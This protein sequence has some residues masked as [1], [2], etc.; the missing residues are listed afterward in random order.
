MKKIIIFALTSLIIGQTFAEDSDHKEHSEHSKHSKSS[1]AL[2]NGKKWEIDQA[3]SENM[4][5][6]MEENKKITDLANSNKA[7]K[8][9][10]NKLSDIIAKS[11][12]NIASNC[13]MEQK[14]DET[15]H[16]VL[17]DLL[18]VSEHLKDSKMPTHAMEKLDKTLK[19]YNQYFNH[20]VSK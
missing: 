13:K 4:S 9:D 16:T 1:L 14:A 3:M 18:I 11:A 17:A 7:K 19:T 5:A 6:I 20:P 8:E 12:Q 2:N 10:Y 15:F